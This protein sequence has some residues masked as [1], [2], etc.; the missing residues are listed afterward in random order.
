MNIRAGFVEIPQTLSLEILAP[1][2]PV[3][4]VERLRMELN[5]Q[6]KFVFGSFARYEMF[7]EE[8]LEF[9]KR[10]LCSVPDLCVDTRRDK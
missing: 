3:G 4:E 7:T 9:A 10:A 8:F 5:L 1:A 6:E 2:V